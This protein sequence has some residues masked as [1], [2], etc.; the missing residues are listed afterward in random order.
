MFSDYL[1][2]RTENPTQSKIIIILDNFESV[3]V[4]LLC[5]Q[6]KQEQFCNIIM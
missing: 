3:E 2:P 4:R 6:S 5:L 1:I